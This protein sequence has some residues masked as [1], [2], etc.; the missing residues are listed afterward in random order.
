MHW[1]WCWYLLQNESVPLAQSL[2]NALCV[3]FC[4]SSTLVGVCVQLLTIH[5]ASW[6]IISVIPVSVCLADDNFQKPWCKMFILAHP[7]YHRGIRVRFVYE[8]HRVKVKVTGAKRIK[9]SILCFSVLLIVAMA[10][11]CS[12]LLI[13]PE[14][15]LFD[16]S[17][18]VYWLIFSHLVDKVWTVMTG[19]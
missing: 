10:W 19:K 18:S 16:L 5:E 9:I 11:R 1:W 14:F 15:A 2:L 12:H 6:Y 8:G 3:S 7:V 13:L 4:H 17:I